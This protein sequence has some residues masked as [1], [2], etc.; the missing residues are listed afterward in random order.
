MN[1][2]AKFR[3]RPEFSAASAT[4]HNPPQLR[5]LR[6]ANGLAAA[7]RAREFVRHFVRHSFGPSTSSLSDDSCA[8]TIAQAS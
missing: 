5:A 8:A 6:I 7:A 4:C 1:E 2:A 3:Q